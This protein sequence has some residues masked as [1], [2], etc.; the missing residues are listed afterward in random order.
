MCAVGTLAAFGHRHACGEAYRRDAKGGRG[1]ADVPRGRRSSRGHLL[2]APR[3]VRG[4]RAVPGRWHWPHA[5][6][7]QQIAAM[8]AQASLDAQ[9][10]RT[11]PAARVLRGRGCSCGPSDACPKAETAQPPKNPGRANQPRVPGAPDAQ[12]PAAVHIQSAWRCYSA[13]RLFLYRRALSG[14][15]ATVIQRAWRLNRA[16]NELN[17]Q[18]GSQAPVDEAHAELAEAAAAPEPSAPFSL[19]AFNT[20]ADEA[21]AALEDAAR[22]AAATVLQAAWRG[23][24]ARWLALQERAVQ[25]AAAEVIQEAWRR[26]RAALY[27]AEHAKE[28]E[29]ARLAAEEAARRAAEEEAARRAAEAARLAEEKRLA[30][31]RARNRAALACLDTPGARRAHAA[32]VI[33]ATF[34]GSQSR[35]AMAALRTRA[36]LRQALAAPDAHAA[37]LHPVAASAAEALITVFTERAKSTKFSTRAPPRPAEDA[38]AAGTGRERVASRLARI[39]AERGEAAAMEEAVREALAWTDVLLPRG[40]AE[41]E[42]TA[43]TAAEGAFLEEAQAPG[44]SPA[45]AHRLSH[46]LAAKVAADVVSAALAPRPQTQAAPALIPGKITTSAKVR[47]AGRRL[48]AAPPPPMAVAAA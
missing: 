18:L 30:D 42:A 7:V 2:R 19:D 6:R 1:K 16:R 48:E 41:A 32:A 17:A 22:H 10:R 21:D 44:A 37:M 34:R 15:A 28:I 12:E 26:R 5:P 36:M 46:R 27:A 9:V 43:C 40:S 31:E 45:G 33:Q 4:E 23:Y 3:P 25:T 13:R 47:E 38:S 29:A 35:R 8:E 20:A 24:S 39:A 11:H 14:G